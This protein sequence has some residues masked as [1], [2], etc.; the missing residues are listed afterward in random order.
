MNKTLPSEQ[1][2]DQLLR[3]FFQ[4]EVPHPWPAFERPEGRMTLP[5]RPTAKPRR[6]FVLGSKLALAAAVALLTLCGWLLSG[7]FDGPTHDANGLPILKGQKATKRP[8][9]DAL[10]APE[11]DKAGDPLDVDFGPER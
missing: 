1:D 11:K 2:V 6:R 9:D 7:S 4:S 5:F 3:S 8:P 10:P